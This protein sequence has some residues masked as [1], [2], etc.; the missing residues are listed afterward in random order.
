MI[1]PLKAIYVP[2]EAHER[3]KSVSRK[4]GYRFVAKRPAKPKIQSTPVPPIQKDALSGF[5]PSRY[6]AELMDGNH[7]RIAAPEYRRA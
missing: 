1:C 3:L 5:V 7:H 6:H 4:S 2:L